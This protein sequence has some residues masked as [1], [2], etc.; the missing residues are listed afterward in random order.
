M[1]IGHRGAAALCPENT[2]SSFCLARDAG[3]GMIELDV[4]QSTD[5]ELFVFHDDTLER[6]CGEPTSVNAL[7]WDLLSPK[8]VG[9]WNEQSV[10]IPR[11]AE[12]FS[13]LQRSVFYNVEIKTDTVAYPGIE[14]RLVELIHAHRLV[15]RVLVSSFHHDSLRLVR[16]HDAKLA[17][18]LLLNLE[19][20]CHLGSPDAMVAC[21]QEYSCFSVHP[22]FRLIRLYPTLVQRCHSAGLQVFPWTVDHPHVWHVLVNDL[23]VDGIITNDPRR[24]YE[25]LLERQI[26]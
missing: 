4:Q 18:G 26:S 9:Y 24:L 5:G 25:W 21:A 10:K 20:G 8:I 1:V 14:A 22:D 19:Q 12:V 13:S 7:S 23:Q 16:E 17:F 2:L 11:L 3:A 15:E 6:L